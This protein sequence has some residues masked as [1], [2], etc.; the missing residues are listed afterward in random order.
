MDMTRIPSGVGALACA[1]A[2]LGDGAPMNAAVRVAGLDHD[3]AERAADALAATGILAPCRPLRFAHPI[4]R[5]AIYVS[6]APGERA[7]AHRRAVR[8]LGEAGADAVAIAAQAFAVEPAGDLHVAEALIDAGRRA[9]AAG[10]PREASLLLERAL[11]EPPAATARA[12]ARMLLGRALT[13]LGDPRSPILAAQ[14]LAAGAPHQRPQLV[15]QLVDALWLTGG[16]DA[17][18]SLARQTAGAEPPGIAAA[19][20]ARAGSLPAARHRA[21]RLARGARRDGV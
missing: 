6:L 11:T 5:A 15:A 1:V 14:A 13:L 7:M 8:A 19:W 16:A 3:D 10:A 18:L 9:L 12:A 21:R 20:A 2:V 17:A 4:L